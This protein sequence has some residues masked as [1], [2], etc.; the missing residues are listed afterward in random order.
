MSDPRSGYESG[1]PQNEYDSRFDLQVQ[2]T[3]TSIAPQASLDKGPSLSHPWDHTYNDSPW[4]PREGTA[5]ISVSSPSYSDGIISTGHSSA[6]TQTPYTQSPHNQKLSPSGCDQ[7][8]L[9][10]VQTGSETTSP[11]GQRFSKWTWDADRKEHWCYDYTSNSYHWSKGGVV[12]GQP[13]N[14]TRSGAAHSLDQPGRDSYPR[15]E[16]AKGM[17]GLTVSGGLQAASNVED[18]R[19]PSTENRNEEHTG[20]PAISTESGSPSVRIDSTTSLK[21]NE[22]V[23]YH[24]GIPTTNIWWDFQEAQSGIPNYHSRN[25]DNGEKGNLISLSCLNTSPSSPVHYKDQPA[26]NRPTR[27]DETTYRTGTTTGEHLGQ[28]VW[29]ANREDYRYES[30]KNS[31]EY[32]KGGIIYAGP[33]LEKPFEGHQD[34]TSQLPITPSYGLP[35]P[36]PA[37]EAFT[38]GGHPDSSPWGAKS[39]T[40]QRVP[41]ER[42]SSLPPLGTVLT[43]PQ[44]NAPSHGTPPENIGLIVAA[45]DTI[46]FDYSGASGPTAV[47]PTH[48]YFHDSIPSPISYVEK[49]T[50][51]IDLSDGNKIQVAMEAPS[52]GRAYVKT[53]ENSGVSKTVD[54][55]FA[56]D[57]TSSSASVAKKVTQQILAFADSA[58]SEVLQGSNAAPKVTLKI[59]HPGDASDKDKA[60]VAEGIR[61]AKICDDLKQVSSTEAAIVDILKSSENIRSPDT[62]SITSGDR[63][64][65]CHSTGSV[66]DATT[67]FVGTDQGSLNEVVAGEGEGKGADSIDEE[68][69]KWMGKTFVWKEKSKKS[70]QAFRTSDIEPGTRFSKEFQDVKTR[71]GSEDNADEWFWLT[72]AM[73]DFPASWQYSNGMIR[74][75]QDNLKSFFQPVLNAVNKV[76]EHQVRQAEYASANVNKV[77]LVGE[78]TRFPYIKNE[79]A[80]WCN[81]PTTHWQ[82]PLHFIWFAR[83]RYALVQGAIYQERENVKVQRKS[84]RHYGY[85]LLLAFEH[86]DRESYKVTDQYD[87]RKLCKNRAS[88]RFAKG[89][90][91]ESNT[92]VSQDCSQTLRAGDRPSPLK[93]ICSTADGQPRYGTDGCVET[94]GSVELAFTFQDL[95]SATPDGPRNGW[96]QPRFRVDVELGHDDMLHVKAVL[97]DGSER[98]VGQSSIKYESG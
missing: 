38:S 77:L 33:D 43:L 25:Q 96:W 84:R 52:T 89:T 94:I 20:Y 82:T 15:E 61:A 86:G 50:C 88:W 31:Y 65:V 78:L 32:A 13:K 23:L 10:Q 11:P 51:V 54:S 66:V 9:S 83:P 64:V 81:S 18:K 79:V 53:L 59:I 42:V 40:Y 22:D 90:D 80:Q 60:D 92:C 45:Q 46:S 73:P 27:S 76:L 36:I 1:R 68:L 26:A 85:V 29:D 71:F 4:R 70:R 41:R 47:V 56:N 37:I 72:L 35:N 87:G 55:F 12:E 16:L 57:R 34:N 67:Y 6:D 74:I 75:S 95:Q 17:A 98:I 28:R 91:I 14:E 39:P 49:V 44:L 3:R 21:A 69:R 48:P 2:S 30:S 97:S 63:V 93:L 58:I 24:T 5:N 19:M 8:N 7:G 62:V